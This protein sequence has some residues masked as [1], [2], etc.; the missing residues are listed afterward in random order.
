MV[1]LAPRSLG[2][3]AVASVLWWWITNGTGEGDLRPYLLLQGLP[4]VL[5][6]LWQA[7]YGAPRSHRLAVGLAIGP[8]RRGEDGRIP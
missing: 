8:L 7:I 5:I 4:L 2:V 3:A 1:P 6:P